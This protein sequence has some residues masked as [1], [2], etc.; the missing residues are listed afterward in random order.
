MSWR[1]SARRLRSTSSSATRTSRAGTARTT[2]SGRRS[3]TSS[4][5]GGSRR[6]SFRIASSAASSTASGHGEGEDQ[7]PICGLVAS[8]GKRDATPV[9]VEGLHRLEYRGYDS[10]G[11]AVVHRGR[12]RITKTAGRVQDLRNKLS[13]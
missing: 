11:L 3:R 2:T 1:T 10:A 12:L 9:L 7:Q 6:A 5:P 8:I 4:R 13:E